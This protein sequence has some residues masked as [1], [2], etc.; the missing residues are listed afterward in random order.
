MSLVTST[1]VRMDVSKGVRYRGVKIE[2]RGRRWRW[3]LRVDGK[4][5]RPSFASLDE[6]KSALD[7]V[8]AQR[9]QDRRASYVEQTNALPIAELCD[10]WFL[11]YRSRLA[12][13]TAYQYGIHIRVHITSG[14]GEVDAN[15][16]RPRELQSF[17]DAL[18]WKPAKESHHILRKA[19]AWGLLNGDLWREQNP[20]LVAKPNR[21]SCVDHDGY[22]DEEGTIHALDEKDVPLPKEVEKL[23]VDAEASD[24]TWW[25]YLKL[26]VNTGARPGEI[27]ALQRKHIDVERRT[28]RIEWSADRVGGR[29]KRP[30]SRGASGG[31]R[32]RPPSSRRSRRS[33]PKIPR[34][35]SSPRTRSR[36]RPRHCRAGTR[37]R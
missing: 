27:C 24:P 13:A 2:G 37:G 20:A 4:R 35:T 12:P 10:R 17:Y 7:N 29:V 25:L 28:V 21:R 3:E 1:F 11:S 16:I 30:K 5:L 31:C 15:T 14:I 34:R 36:G 19:F 32:S 6:A 33:C 23:L 22:Y 18:R 9:E 8:M 26:A